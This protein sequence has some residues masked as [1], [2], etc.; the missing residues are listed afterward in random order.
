MTGRWEPA[1]RW[2]FCYRATGGTW[3][4]VWRWIAA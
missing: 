3:K 4:Q 1:G 2:Q